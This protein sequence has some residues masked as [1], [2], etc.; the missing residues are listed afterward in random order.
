MSL[1]SGSTFVMWFL[2]ACRVRNDPLYLFVAL[3]MQ[4]PSWLKNVIGSA[5]QRGCLLSGMCTEKNLLA[6]ASLHGSALS[7]GASSSLTLPLAIPIWGLGSC[8]LWLYLGHAVLELLWP[9]GKKM[10]IWE[11]RT[12]PLETSYWGKGIRE[13]TLCKEESGLGFPF[14]KPSLNLEIFH[15]GL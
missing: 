5:A 3:D 2:L 1:C 14:P 6:F 10:S 7:A 9:L 12:Q 15:S 13:T 4:V 11:R 8:W